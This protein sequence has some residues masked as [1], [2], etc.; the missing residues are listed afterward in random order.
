[1]CCVMREYVIIQR[2]VK[3]PVQDARAGRVGS[4]PPPPPLALLAEPCG[5]GGEEVGEPCSAWGF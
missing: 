5:G 2:K 1:M 3:V 4:S